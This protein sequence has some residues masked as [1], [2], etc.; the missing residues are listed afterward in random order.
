MIQ[1]SIRSFCEQ[2]LEAL[3]QKE[4]G[5][6]ICCMLKEK[7]EEQLESAF[8]EALRAHNKAFGF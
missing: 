1:K 3:L 7:Q 5:L 2:N 8:P 6:F 4:T